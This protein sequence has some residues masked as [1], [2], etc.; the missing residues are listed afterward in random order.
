MKYATCPG[1]GWYRC[2]PLIGEA[3]FLLREVRAGEDQLRNVD[4]GLCGSIAHYDSWEPIE[5]PRTTVQPRPLPRVTEG[6]RIVNEVRARLGHDPFPPHEW[7]PNSM[8]RLYA[9]AIDA[10]LERA[11]RE[12]G[13]AALRDCGLRAAASR[14]EFG[15]AWLPE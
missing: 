15:E 8:T 14:I 6:E 1:P 11:R 2:R 12:G 9:D 5:D 7:K 4:G 13:A 10:A 3:T